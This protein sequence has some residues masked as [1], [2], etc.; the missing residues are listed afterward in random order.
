MTLQ[1]VFSCERKINHMFFCKYFFFVSDRRIETE[2]EIKSV[3]LS[4]HKKICAKLLE[5]RLFVWFVDQ[6]IGLL[7]GE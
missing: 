7:A 2:N 1:D 3:K 6:N 4:A 5:I